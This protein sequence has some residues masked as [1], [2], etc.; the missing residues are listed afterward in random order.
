MCGLGEFNVL[1]NLVRYINEPAFDCLRK[2]ATADILV[3][4]RSSFSYLAGIL[5]RNG[6]IMYHP[7]WHRPLSPW[8]T[9][10]PEGQFD[11]AKFR[12]ATKSA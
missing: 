4:S 12:M 10:G 2:L 11:Q 8:I 9:V 1:A 6:V 5:N 7:F 3:M